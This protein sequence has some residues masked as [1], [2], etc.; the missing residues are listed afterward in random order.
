[1]ITRVDDRSP[2]TSMIESVIGPC[3]A[4]GLDGASATVKDT[5]RASTTVTRK[6]RMN[7]SRMKSRQVELAGDDLHHA[8]ADADVGGAPALG[9]EPDVNLAGAAHLDA[10]LA[11][12]LD[13]GAVGDEAVAHE[14]GAQRPTRRAR[15]RILGN[16]GRVGREHP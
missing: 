7:S 13:V 10:L 4:G 15:G 2:E 1:M 3:A 11:E 14:V 8:A 12:D 5:K 16:A 9:V 6:R